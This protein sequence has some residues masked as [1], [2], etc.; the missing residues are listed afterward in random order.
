MS[1]E[2]CAPSNT[3]WG[4]NVGLGDVENVTYRLRRA[5]KRTMEMR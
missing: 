3:E 1:P 5:T 2:R 4:K